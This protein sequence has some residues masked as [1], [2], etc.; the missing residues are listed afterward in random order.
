MANEVRIGIVFS[1]AKNGAQIN[2]TEHYEADVAGDSFTHETQE[3][4]TSDEALVYPANF[5]NYTGLVFVKN[6][7]ASY[8]IEIGLT[9]SYTIKLLAGESNIISAA[10]ALFA[11][12]TGGSA[13]LEYCLIE[14]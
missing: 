2:R 8:Y 5:T 12:A 11:K 10:G 9:S 13:N 7:H 1:Y 6:L 3:I 14:L 4:G